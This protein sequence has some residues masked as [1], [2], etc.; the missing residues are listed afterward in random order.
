VAIGIPQGSP[1]SPILFLLYL[2]PLFDSLQLHYPIIWSLSYINN[3]ALVAQGRTREGNSRALEVAARTAFQ[4]AQDNVVA[5]D[6]AKSEM[7]HFHHSRQDIITEEIKI[8]LP[9]GMVVEPGTRGGK[10]DMVRWIG[11]F[12]DRKR[13]FKYH[14][15]TK[16]MVAT[17]AFNALRSLV[18]HEIGLSPSA[19]RLIYQAYVTSRSNFGAEIW[20]Q[21]QKNLE[22]TLQLQQNTALHKILNA[23][24]STPVTALHNEAALPPVAVRLTHKL[25]KYTLCLLCLPTTY[26]VV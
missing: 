16:V 12:F 4:W 19:K 17:H 1:A 15:T 10:S 5:F 25:C 7:L 18:R 8:R 11:I 26:L 13:T 3:V 21:G 9:H 2:H 14:V 20:W 6:D 24:Q 22:T 23:F